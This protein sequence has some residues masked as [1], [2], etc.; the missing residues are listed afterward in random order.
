MKFK[1]G[2]EIVQWGANEVVS[3]GSVFLLGAGEYCVA[4]GEFRDYTWVSAQHIDDK[5]ELAPAQVTTEAFNPPDEGFESP[6]GRQ[7]ARREIDARISA[8]RQII[9]L[10]QEE[11][12]ELEERR[13]SMT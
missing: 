2:D 13:Q 5:Y 8:K 9:M 3:W 12:T 10:L 6:R 1:V 4:F 11:I 7:D